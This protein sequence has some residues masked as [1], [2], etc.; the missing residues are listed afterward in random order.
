ME[1]LDLRHQ[2]VVIRVDLNV[3][4]KNGK[5]LNDA[6]IQAILPTLQL[7]L[8]QQAAII[9][10]SHL[11]QPKEGEEDPALSLK[12]IAQH[13]Q[14]IF[15]HPVRF[16]KH[17]LN[18][19]AI[20]PGEIVLCENV[21]FN[22]GEAKAD[23]LLAKQMA[24]LGDV[25]VMDAFAVAHRAQASTV[26][27]TQYAKKVA[28]GPLLMS[29]LNALKHV[30]EN[31]RRPLLAVVGGAKVSS[32]LLVLES[33]ILQVNTLIL[34]GGIANTFIA[35]QGG[36]V[37]QSLY[38]PDLIAKA[39]ELIDL[40]EK[41][42]VDLVIPE[43]VVVSTQ[44]SDS[45]AAYVRSTAMILPQEKILDVGPQT[46]KRCQALIKAAGT[47]IW[48]GPLGVFEYAPFAEGTK[49]LAQAI[50]NASAFSLAG[51]GETLAAIDKFSV[52]DKISY[53]STGGG[54]FLECLEGKT[55]PV[56]AALEARAYTLRE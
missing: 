19:I 41:Q 13:L 55:L 33:L 9:L 26:G 17:W 5:I 8:K 6:R 16:E 40:A 11:G 21:R 35:A 25:F 42:K 2:Q 12:P 15:K 28:A 48:N 30:F 56:V 38:E 37:G 43:E 44:L 50:A 4:M 52:K 46:I 14:Q 32:K 24:S 18:G 54:A 22:Q 29:E 20:Q 1:Q 34:G 39:K 47:I 36:R 51:G 23:P 31:P 49:A 53:L 10:L 27:I 7:A 45:A 3:P